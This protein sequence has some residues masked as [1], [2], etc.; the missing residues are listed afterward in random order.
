MCLRALIRLA[1]SQAN[2]KEDT[3]TPANTAMAKS[4]ITVITVTNTITIISDLGTLF[5]IRNEFH[6]KVPK[7]TINI[8]PTKAAMGTCS[9]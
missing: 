9:I 7:T 2:T 1:F 4:K 3:T 6:A 5:Q 8:T